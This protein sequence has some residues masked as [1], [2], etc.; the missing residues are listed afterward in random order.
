[1]NAMRRIFSP[2]RFAFRSEAKRI[3]QI[4]KLSKHVSRSTS[5]HANPKGLA[6]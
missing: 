4:F 2:L 3:M 1:M 6:E 5:S